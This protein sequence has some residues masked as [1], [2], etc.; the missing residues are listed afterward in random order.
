MVWAPACVAALLVLFAPRG[1][2]AAPLIL[3]LPD[4]VPPAAVSEGLVPALVLDEDEGRLLHGLGSGGYHIRGGPREGVLVSID[5]GA[6]FPIFTG[7]AEASPGFAA[8]GLVGYEFPN[9]V[10][11][12]F[13]YQDLGLAP[14]LVDRTQWQLATVGMRY[15][16]PYI[17]PMPFVEALVGASFVNSA[18][19]FNSGGATVSVS[20]GGA[21][22]LGLGLPLSRHV[23]VDL[24]ARDWISPVGPSAFQVLVVDLG[25]TVSFGAPP[26]PH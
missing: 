5:A 16:F 17:V 26:R 13:R 24:A 23:A 6:A 19:P 9:G 14:T 7:S 3:S 1:A 25:L 12:E 10:A 20:P 21:A 2:R 8:G 22:G 15:T 4:L 18:V 11:L